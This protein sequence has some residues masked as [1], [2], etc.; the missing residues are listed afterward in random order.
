[1][2]V[3]IMNEK[4]E[5]IFSRRSVRN[6]TAEPVSDEEIRLILEAAMAAPSACCKDPWRF[7][8][9]NKHEVKQEIANHLPNG[10][11]LPLAPVCIV[12]L[13]DLEQAHANSESFLLQDC[14]AAIENI[15]LAVTAMGL[16]ACWLG[17]HPRPERIKAIRNYF[18]LPNNILPVSVVA[19]G[20][21]LKTPEA[22]TRFKE[23]CV[24]YNSWE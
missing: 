9:V 4:L 21:P 13:G 12:V 14:S 17:V 23:S 10:H 7:I 8:V 19:I 1:M 5:L 11:F 22:R 20:H 16:G 3:E 24:K 15:L 6:F 18:Q 2:R